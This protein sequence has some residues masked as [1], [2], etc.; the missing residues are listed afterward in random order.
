MDKDIDHYQGNQ[1]IRSISLHIENIDYDRLVFVFSFVENVRSVELNG[2]IDFEIDKIFELEK[3]F[4]SFRC[5]LEHLI[6]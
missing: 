2:R 5:N 3:T 1:S 6:K 4:T